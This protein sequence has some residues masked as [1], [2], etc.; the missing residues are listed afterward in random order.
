VGGSPVQQDVEQAASLADEAAH[1]AGVS[2]RDLH[3][4]AEAADVS[5][6]FD[7]VWGREGEHGAMMAREALLALAGA[8]AQLTGAYDGDLVGATV[9]FVGLS[10]DRAVYLHSHI[11]GVVPEA[12]GRGVGRALKLHQRA[13]CLQRGITTVRWTFDPLVRRNAVFNLVGL[14]AQALAYEP[15][16]Y[17]TVD[18]A[19]NAGMPT[20]RLL[21]SWD[22]TG[23]RTRQALSGRRAEPDVAAVRRSGAEVAVDVDA[24]DSPVVHPTQAPRRLVRVPA[25]IEA[26]RARDPDLA[27]RWS[28]VVREQLGA[29]M[30]AGMRV[31]GMTRDGW[32]LLA[33]PGGVEELSEQR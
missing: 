22:L 23:P 25:D 29:P 31:T 30:Q 6:L 24:D 18:D 7:R 15:D 33:T 28:E 12:T 10:P 3:T 26:L 21:A 17:G 16:R 32:Y 2:V 4:P 1:D 13:W 5:A 20:D 19:R 9:A 27:R 14:G 11:T 8:G